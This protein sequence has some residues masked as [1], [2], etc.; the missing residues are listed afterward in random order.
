V[1]PPLALALCIGFVMY[2][3]AVERYRGTQ[4]SPGG[5]VPLLWLLII[6]T[7]EVSNWLNLQT[8]MA[9]SEYYLEGNATDRVVYAT[10]I[11]LGC[12]ILMRRGFSW[13]AAVRENRA[14]ALFV[15]YCGLSVLW[16]DYPLVA[17]KRWIKDVGIIVMAFVVLSDRDPREAT[18]ALFTRWSYILIP[19]SV[20][21]IKYFPE[22]GKGYSFTGQ[23]FYAGV[24]TS[25]NSLG[26][27]CLITTLWIAWTLL[28]KKERAQPLRTAVLLNYAML[29]ALVVWLGI[30]VNSATSLVCVWIGVVTL[31]LLRMSKQG[32]GRVAPTI[33][34]LA[35]VLVTVGTVFDGWNIALSY[36]GRD[37]TLTGRT[38]IWER[39]LNTDINPLVGTG[40]GSFWL[41]NR[42]A[43]FWDDYE[44]RINQ[45]HNGYL[46]V[47]LNLGLFGIGLVLTL[48]AAAYRKI[49]SRFSADLSLGA[50]RFTFLIIVVLYNIAEASFTKLG[51]MWFMAMLIMLERVPTAAEQPAVVSGVVRPAYVVMTANPGLPPAQFGPVGS[52]MRKS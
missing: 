17:L 21:L 36:L 4:L 16:S 26:G 50:F 42:A 47:Y 48:L 52:Q 6:S 35:I 12:V 10:L 24:T 49:S 27:L 37:A 38:E 39:V 1:P 45:A 19:F 40:F 9:A 18:R 11:V 44:F 33:I 13:S 23:A 22:L 8:P 31:F 34:A 43:G 29:M 51:P 5:W 2:L 14:V 3:F 41:G 28:I 32:I 25:K 30:R 46:E 15:V 20:V 7:R